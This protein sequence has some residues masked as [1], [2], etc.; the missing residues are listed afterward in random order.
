MKKFFAVVASLAALMACLA[1]HCGSEAEDAEVEGKVGV[2]WFFSDVVFDGD[3]KLEGGLLVSLPET[4]HSY[5]PE[6]GDFGMP[7][8]V[9]ITNAAGLEF[10]KPRFPPVKAFQDTAGTAYGYSGAFM[11]RFEIKLADKLEAKKFNISIEALLCKD[12]C[13]PV[14][15]QLEIF[16]PDADA[17]RELLRKK[18]TEALKSGL[19]KNE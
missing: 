10:S 7:P 19:W 16:L 18:W 6:P 1:V 2:E 9:I 15:R 17:D 11:I 12:V 14:E 3:G 5:G 8:R 4:W 13:I